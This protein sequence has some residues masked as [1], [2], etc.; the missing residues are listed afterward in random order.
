[1]LLTVTEPPKGADV[2]SAGGAG[3][4]GLIWVPVLRFRVGP[5]PVAVYPSFF[6][7]AV[8][9]GAGQRAS[10]AAIA[11]WVF[12]VFTSV[13]VHELGHAVVGLTLGGRPEIKLE[14]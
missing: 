1:M 6:I 13:L 9:L 12:V 2:P 14:G 4:D 7:A 3:Q 11:G 10:L 5:F 8:V